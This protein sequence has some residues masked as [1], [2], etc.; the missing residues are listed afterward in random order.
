MTHV[1]DASTRDG[2]EQLRQRIRALLR[3]DFSIA[4]PSH[5]AFKRD[6]V[7]KA[8]GADLAVQI[9][10]LV[11]SWAIAVDLL[12]CCEIPYSWDACLRRILIEALDVAPP[13]AQM[14]Y[15]LRW[16]GRWCWPAFTALLLLWVFSLLG[17]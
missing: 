1:E 11:R 8:R 6:T 16:V 9:D 17:W 12:S 7:I 13:T 10:A 4:P 2:D 5:L 15:K 3:G 14:P